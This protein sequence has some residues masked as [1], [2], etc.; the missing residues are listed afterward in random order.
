MGAGT[1]VA[2]SGL[3]G[4]TTICPQEYTA[5]PAIIPSPSTFG[6]QNSQP[7][8]LEIKKN[9][10]GERILI[11]YYAVY[12]P[13]N[14]GAVASV[15]IVS[16]PL[17]SCLGQALNPIATQE[18]EQLLTNPQLGGQF[19]NTV[20]PQAT[21]TNWENGPVSQDSW[22][23][24]LFDETVAVEAYTGIVGN[25]ND[26][27]YAVVIAMARHTNQSEAVL[28]GSGTAKSLPPDANPSGFSVVPTA[29][30]QAEV[31]DIKQ[32]ILSV[33]P[34]IQK[35]TASPSDAQQPTGGYGFGGYGQGGYG[36]VSG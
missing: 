10:L 13:T 15:G 23:G 36:G 3:A 21:S 8:R 7:Q 5:P 35:Q 19:V 24:T 26:T 18:F 34:R 2:V 9:V 6:L 29:F 31:N 12:E 25:P 17:V 20:A 27:L 4:C 11:N 16:T 22:S 30:S 28:V 14:E 32:L 1:G 33:L